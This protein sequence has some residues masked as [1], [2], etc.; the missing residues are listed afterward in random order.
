MCRS[1]TVLR[2]S[3][4]CFFQRCCAPS[5]RSSTVFPR[6]WLLSTCGRISCE[7]QASRASEVIRFKD[8]P[9]WAMADERF[10]ELPLSPLRCAAAVCTGHVCESEDPPAA[11]RA[12]RAAGRQRQTG[13]WWWWSRK[14]RRMRSV[15]LSD[16]LQVRFLQGKNGGW[17][18]LDGVATP[19]LVLALA[20]QAVSF[21]VVAG[22]R[23]GLHYVETVA[24]KKQQRCVRVRMCQF[25]VFLI[26]SLKVFSQI[27]ETC[28]L[29]FLLLILGI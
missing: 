23:H 8:S 10:N 4:T 11:G 5:T 25:R 18:H 20:Q 29:R 13:R 2:C 16:F 17:K 26:A 15:R 28:W 22:H 9:T 21:N 27:Q 3:W 14:G 24:R 12:C 7:A 19:F 1:N 6:A